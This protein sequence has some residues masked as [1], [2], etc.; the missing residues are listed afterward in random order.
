[1]LATHTEH[2]VGHKVKVS[3]T[4]KVRRCLRAVKS[5]QNMALQETELGGG[6]PTRL[7]KHPREEGSYNV[8]ISRLTSRE[9]AEWG[10]FPTRF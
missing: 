10:K 6:R 1:M 7:N 3:M 2:K 4:I 8:I 9:S 5:W